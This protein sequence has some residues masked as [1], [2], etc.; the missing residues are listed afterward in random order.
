ME[1]RIRGEEERVEEVTVCDGGR[2]TWRWDEGE[3]K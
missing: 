1:E 3:K 2:G